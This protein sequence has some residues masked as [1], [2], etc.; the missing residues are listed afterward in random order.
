MKLNE[1]LSLLNCFTSNLFYISILVRFAMQFS[2]LM[3]LCRSTLAKSYYS[4][5]FPSWN[6]YNT[7]YFDIINEAFCSHEFYYVDLYKPGFKL[8]TSFSLI[9]QSQACLFNKLQLQIEFFIISNW[10]SLILLV[11]F[12]CIYI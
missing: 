4:L 9:V 6:R 2:S 12:L 8:M 10:W 11:W 1:Y 3:A 7:I 5:C